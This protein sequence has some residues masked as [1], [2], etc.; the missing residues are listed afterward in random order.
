MNEKNLSIEEVQHK[1]SDYFEGERANFGIRS[2]GCSI[3]VEIKYWDFRPE[4]RV[5]RDIEDISDNVQI[6]EITRRITD[7]A[8]TAM[9]TELFDREVTIYTKGEDNALRETTLMQFIDSHAIN[10]DFKTK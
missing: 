1:I 3:L 7:A 6:V 8:Y 2:Y 10:H 4:R 5:R 9:L